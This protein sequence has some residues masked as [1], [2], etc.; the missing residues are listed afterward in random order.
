MKVLLA[1]MM[2]MIFPMNAVA[3]TKWT[4]ESNGELIIRPFENAPY[5]HSSRENGYKNGEKTFPKDPHYVDSSVGIFIPKSFVGDEKVNYVVHFHGWGNSVSKVFSQFKLA[6]QLA[7]SKVNA[8][9][10]VPQ[11]PKDA[12]DSG[13]GKL[14]L[15]KDGFKNLIDEV[16]KFLNAEGKIKTSEVGSI[17]LSAHSGGYKVTA[18]IL[19]HGGLTDKITDVLLLDASYGSLPW[20]VD[21]AKGGNR[22]LVSLFT[23]HLSDENEE[24]MTLMKKADIAYAE[25]DEA[26]LSPEQLRQREPIFMPTKL[27]HNDVPMKNE[28][29]RK[30]LETSALAK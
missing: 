3:E 20:F 12:S 15:D 16:T 19:D 22:R 7:D 4:Q 11:G 30:L 1:M 9:L 14:E 28:Y 26:K 21:Y 29:F 17:V 13:C 27:A 10:L 8:I 5:P 24:I 25:V 18:A 6:Q 23:E 2:V